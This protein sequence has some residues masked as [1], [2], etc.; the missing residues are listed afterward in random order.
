MS[1]TQEA[2]YSIFGKKIQISS[3]VAGLN[4]RIDQEFSL[5]PSGGSEAADFFIEIVPELAFNEQARN[6]SIHSE[7]AD[8]LYIRNQQADIS[9]EFREG[10]LFKVSFQLNKALNIFYRQL[11][12]ALSIQYTSR[13]ERIG[14]ILHELVLI[15]MVYFM[16]DRIPVHGSAVEID[17][18]VI[19]LGGTGGVGKT[20]LELELCLNQ[21]ALFLADDISVLSD[22][23]YV[24]PNLN[25]PKLYG[26]NLQNDSKLTQ[27]A[28]KN[29]TGFDRLHWWLHSRRGLEKVRRRIAPDHLYGDFARKEAQLKRYLI[30]ALQSTEDILI[31][32]ISHEEAAKISVD[33][34]KTEYADFNNHLYWHRLNAK[35]LEKSAFFDPNSIFER[36]EE[37]LGNILSDVRCDLVKIP[38]GMDHTAFRERMAGLITASG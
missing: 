13:E 33:I 17:G 30:L 37:Q 28:V 2:V 6:P 12:K 34:L 14:Q 25:F 18:Q 10:A 26:Y 27:K 21:D 38:I 8:A 35:V 32:R 36:W 24:F 4:E 31:D 3:H 9:L 15:P 23:G 7:N 19:L 5:Y 11:Q 1:L 22:A 29:S 16:K 20:S